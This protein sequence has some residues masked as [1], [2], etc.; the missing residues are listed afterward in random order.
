MTRCE[1]YTH[2]GQAVQSRHHRG[3]QSQQCRAWFL[4]A[5]IGVGRSI[6]RHG[7][8]LIHLSIYPFFLLIFDF[9]FTRCFPSPN[10]PGRRQEA[11]PGSTQRLRW[12]CLSSI[13]YEATE[14]V[15]VVAVDRRDARGRSEIEALGDQSPRSRPNW[16]FPSTIWAVISLIR[17]TLGGP[18]LWAPIRL[19]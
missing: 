7:I 6:H 2:T 12:N 18:V 10:S 1:S 19:W 13:C 5:R 11:R 4:R 8:G 3:H 9:L 17:S 15:C 14:T 16:K